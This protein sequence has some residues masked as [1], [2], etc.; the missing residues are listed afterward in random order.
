MDNDKNNAT[1]QRNEIN[2]DEEL[3]IQTLEKSQQQQIQN[4]GDRIDISFQNLAKTLGTFIVLQ[5][6]D[7]LNQ[8]KNKDPPKG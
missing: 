6:K 4:L 2:N 1:D 7:Q 3:L 5:L 8:S